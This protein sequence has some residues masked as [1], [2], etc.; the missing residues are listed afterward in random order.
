MQRRFHRLWLLLLAVFLVCLAAGCGKADDSVSEQGVPDVQEHALVAKDDLK[1]GVLYIA[2]PTVGSGYSYAHDLG[3]SDMMRNLELRPEQVERAVVPDSDAA[4]VARAAEKFIADGCQVVIGT[5][6]GYMQ[7]LAALAEKHPQV[8]FA[9]SSGFLSNGR[10]FINYFG[11]IYQAR[12]LSGIV[13]GLN[14][15]TG[16]IGYV[17]AQGAENA[18]V[19][20][21]IDAFAIGVAEVNPTARVY[22]RVT[23][24]WF[25][26]AAERAASEELLD[27]GCDVMS[28]HCDT[29]APVRL[30]QQ[31]GVYAI[32]YNSDM[33]KECPKATLTSVIWGWGAF[34]TYY[35]NSLLTGTYDGENYYRGMR[36]GMVELTDVADFAADGTAEQVEAA[37]KRIMDGSCNVFDGV[38]ET[39]AGTTVGTAGKTLSDAE[40]TGGIHWYY[41]NVEVLP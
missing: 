9:H 33:S 16:K 26:P 21:G 18:E 5:S 25:D 35:I 29:D 3:I 31:R 11:R 28:Q 24:S 20:G 38:L 30:A 36:D 1:I 13:A 14:T 10:N 4:G 15:K 8:Y 37:K 39:N 22:V 32:G 17:A 23:H 7:T 27:L 34:Y 12:Y 19:T 6:F 2:D 40:I 41:K